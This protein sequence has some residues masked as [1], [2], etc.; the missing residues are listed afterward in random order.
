M[1]TL[2]IGFFIFFSSFTFAQQIWEALEGP[3]N[4][5]I[6]CI[7][8]GWV[9]TDDGIYAQ[10]GLN[11]WAFV[12]LKGNKI[13][14][15]TQAG[16]NYLAA[17]ENGVY[18]S[19]DGVN[20]TKSPSLSSRVH[21]FR[22]GYS[23]SELYAASAGGM[24]LSTDNGET[25]SGFAL[26]SLAD[27]NDLTGIYVGWWG[28]VTNIGFRFSTDNGGTWNDFNNGLPISGIRGITSV[29]YY[30]SDNVLMITSEYGCFFINYN[31]VGDSTKS[32]EQRNNGLT[33]TEVNCYAMKDEKI[34]IGTQS[35]IFYTTDKGANWLKNSG[36]DFE[37]TDLQDVVATSL[38][39][40]I[41]KAP[42]IIGNAN[43]EQIGHTN[44]TSIT[45]DQFNNLYLGT[46]GYGV[47]K[48]TDNGYSF[49]QINSGLTNL[50]INDLVFDV[51]HN[52]FAATNQGAFKSTDYG[53][54][55]QSVLPA[56]AKIYSLITSARGF[57]LET[58]GGGDASFY[59]LETNNNWNGG[60]NDLSGA[61]Y[62][63]A[64][65]PQM[66]K[67]IAACDGGVFSSA[68]DYIAWTKIDYNRCR[69]I[70]IGKNGEIFIGL[71]GGNIK[72]STDNGATWEDAGWISGHIN[73]LITDNDGSI[74]AAHDWGISKSTN[75]GT[76][77][78]DFIS[79]VGVTGAGKETLCLGLAGGGIMYAGTLG[80]GLF[81]SINPVSEVNSEIENIPTEFSLSQN[82]PNPFNPSTIIKYSVPKII[83]NQSSI[84]NLKIYDILGNEIATLV[85]EQMAPGNYNISFDA[86]GLSSGIYFYKLTDGKNYLT[87]KMILLK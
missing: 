32:W 75:N 50:I 45:F 64:Y 49:S 60:T 84:I 43:Y 17:V 29:N 13:N 41:Y 4:K 33:N 19:S 65:S 10:T 30:A 18:Y 7:N 55:W 61:V 48:S 67:Y 15:I 24:F 22:F 40:G 42:N 38:Y 25:W 72:R 47:Y 36:M 39:N 51:D 78:G 2:T 71:S 83:N 63:I 86:S 11:T 80:L 6:Y 3:V 9:G 23:S 54:T 66:N 87:K 70:T 14:D 8:G 16:S 12:G 76:N 5:E 44:Y 73:A 1:K 35:G 26:N 56:T 81:K 28:I 74:Y 59:L 34:R 77:W 20:W 57:S 52:L 31:E 53:T 85:N 27:I 82:Y 68:T 37:I 21:K 69:A 79:G 58:F 46:G 62:D